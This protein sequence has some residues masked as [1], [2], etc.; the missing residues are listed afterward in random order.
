MDKV[1]NVTPEFTGKS[2]PIGKWSNW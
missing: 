2:G 1:N